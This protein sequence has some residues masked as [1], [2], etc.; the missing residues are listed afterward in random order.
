MI[1]LDTGLVAAHH[2]VGLRPM[3]GCQVLRPRR[4]VLSNSPFNGG[5]RWLAGILGVVVVGA[6]AT[7]VTKTI[8]NETAIAVLS[9]KMDTMHS[10]LKEVRADVK[11]IERSLP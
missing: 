9:S 8:Q 11:Q 7:A 10:L 3:D 5:F 1:G 4:I 2:L 6:G